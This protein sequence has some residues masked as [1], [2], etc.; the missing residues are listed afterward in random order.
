MQ[1]IVSNK[2]NDDN[3]RASHNRT[4]NLSLIITIIASN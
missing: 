2:N 1:R 4:G 3:I